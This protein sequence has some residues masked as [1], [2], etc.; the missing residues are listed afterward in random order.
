MDIQTGRG[1]QGSAQNSS[2]EARNSAVLSFFRRSTARSLSY[3]R[4]AVDWNS[5][6]VSLAAERSSSDRRPP[7]RMSYMPGSSYL[8]GVAEDMSAGASLAGFDSTQGSG[9]TVH[10]LSLLVQPALG[11]VLPL[12][13][14][15]VAL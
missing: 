7:S 3:T 5:P 2:V 8:R 9:L 14:D 12:Q 10:H 15:V 13:D 11:L 1:D 6:Q 4:H